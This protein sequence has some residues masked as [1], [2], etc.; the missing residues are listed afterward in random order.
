MRRPTPEEYVIRSACVLVKTEQEF[1][2]APPEEKEEKRSELR[3]C[4][5]QL[6]T[7]VEFYMK[8][9]PF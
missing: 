3:Q 8:Q 4:K 5:L 9:K 7:S 1:L 2:A 6:R